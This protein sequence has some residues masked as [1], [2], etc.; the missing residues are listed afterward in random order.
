MLVRQIKYIKRRE[1]TRKN[2]RNLKIL[3]INR[4]NNVPLINN[5]V[6]IIHRRNITPFGL[7]IVYSIMK[8]IRTMKDTIFY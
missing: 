5:S 1:C 8:M 6:E 4:F 2:Q 3:T 7:F